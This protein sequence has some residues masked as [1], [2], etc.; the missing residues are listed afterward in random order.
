MVVPDTTR[1]ESVAVGTTAVEVAPAAN[2]NP[3]R[4]IYLRN[5]STGV[6][7]LNVF[8][9]SKVATSGGGGIVL[10]PGEVIVDASDGSYECYQGQITAVSD[11]AAGT[12]AVFE[13]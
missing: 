1:N 10:K 11:I 5:T 4:V 8:F 12:L 13:R 6:Q 2:A 7:A 3:R 9:G